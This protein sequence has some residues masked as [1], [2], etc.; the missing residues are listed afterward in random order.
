M[1]NVL[2]DPVLC[3][4][5]KELNDLVQS[6]RLLETSDILNGTDTDGVRKM[7]L[8]YLESLDKQDCYTLYRV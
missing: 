6:L 4:A 8:S 1:K 5:M 2:S 7:L 3:R